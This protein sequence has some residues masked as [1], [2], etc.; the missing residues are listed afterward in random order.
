MPS[1]TAVTQAGKQARAAL[2][3]HQAQAAGAHGGE[4]GEVAQ[5]GDEDAVL[6]RHL[7]DGLLFA[8]AHLAAID[9]ESLDADGGFG[10]HSSAS[11]FSGRQ[12]PQGWPAM[13]DSYSWRK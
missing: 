9:G 12:V 5:G 8:G 7:E 10:A 6:A 3:F 11:F 2:D 13:W 1:A 4:A